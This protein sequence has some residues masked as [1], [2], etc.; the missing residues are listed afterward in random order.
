M[1]DD[2]IYNRRIELKAK[3]EIIKLNR[4]YS[5]VD[6]RIWIDKYVHEHHVYDKNM[7]VWMW[8][9]FHN[10]SGVIVSWENVWVNSYMQMYKSLKKQPIIVS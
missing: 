3:N 2:D 4:D 5:N 8:G 9:P 1:T 7:W 6:K 10:R